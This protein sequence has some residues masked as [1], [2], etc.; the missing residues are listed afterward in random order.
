[1]AVYHLSPLVF[2]F[3]KST[4]VKMVGWYYKT[5][6]ESSVLQKK[7]ILNF[8]LSLTEIPCDTHVHSLFSFSAVNV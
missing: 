2:H 6:R 3:V 8:P 7:E 4:S 5:E 1:M